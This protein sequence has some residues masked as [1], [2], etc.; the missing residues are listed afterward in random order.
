MQYTPTTLN[1][2]VGQPNIRRMLRV[3]VE[4]SLKRNR[5]CPHILLAGP[6]GL[7]KS[8]LAKYSG[9]HAERQFIECL[10]GKLPRGRTGKSCFYQVEGYG[11][12]KMD[13]EEARKIALEAGCRGTCG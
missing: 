7:G 6:S 12:K 8:T 5:P 10:A 2:F 11:Y 4:A 1:E 9:Y 3:N 13:A